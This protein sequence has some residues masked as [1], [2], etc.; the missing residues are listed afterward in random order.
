M[1]TGTW[2]GIASLGERQDAPGAPGS[3]RPPVADRAGMFS[4]PCGRGTQPLAIGSAASASPWR[5]PAETRPVKTRTPTAAAGRER[6]DIAPEGASR[7]LE[8]RPGVAG[9]GWS[10]VHHV[11]VGWGGHLRGPGRK[12]MRDAVPDADAG[13]TS[14]ALGKVVVREVDDGVA[15]EGWKCRHC[16]PG[17]CRCLRILPGV[18]GAFGILS[19]ACS[20]ADS[21]K[22][23]PPPATSAAAGA[24][25]TNPAM[26][27]TPT[28]THP[29]GAVFPESPSRGAA[30]A[31]AR[32][33]SACTSESAGC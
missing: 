11:D 2:Q 18:R 26:L 6:P 4:C 29:S 21:A 8:G 14:M 24:M 31:A 22:A 12:P 23:S 32:V 27:Q 10:A 16:S 13:V 25:R 7:Q 30:S 15:S 9:C 33:S 28:R 5:L 19:L 1:D 3:D 17:R 20:R